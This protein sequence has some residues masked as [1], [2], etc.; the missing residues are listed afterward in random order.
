M[1]LPQLKKQ[2]ELDCVTE[3]QPEGRVQQGERPR[4]TPH[5]WAPLCDTEKVTENEGQAPRGR[6][7]KDH[8]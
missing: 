1:L 6:S 7:C 5:G 4:G 2:K 3:G 8:L